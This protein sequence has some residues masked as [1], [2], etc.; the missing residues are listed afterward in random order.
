M[1]TPRDAGHTPRSLWQRG[2][3]GWPERFPVAQFPNA[4]LIVAF[5][6]WA[7]AAATDGSVHHYARATFYVG[8]AAW[9]WEELTD[10]VNWFRRALGAGGLVYVVA[11]VGDALS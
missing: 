5:G 8:L 2:Q 7:V 3:H 9:G 1:T 6:G 10:G 11:Q 4:P